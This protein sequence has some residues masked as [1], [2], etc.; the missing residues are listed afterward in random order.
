MLLT[1]GPV[2][3]PLAVVAAGAAP[4]MHHRSDEFRQLLGV[5]ATRL[6][7]L[8]GSTGTV[9]IQAGS[10]TLAMQAAIDN[11]CAPGDYAVVCRTGEFAA[12]FVEMV[13]AAGGVA[14]PVDAPP[15][16]ALPPESLAE[17][18]RKVSVRL[19]CLQHVDTSSGIRNDVAALAAVARAVGAYVV[20]DGVASV[21]AEHVCADAHG[22]DV[23]VTA[24]QK[25]LMCPPGV[26]IQVIS[27]RA[28]A[29][30]RPVAPVYTNWT[31]RPAE[32]GVICNF[33]AP[34]NGVRALNAAT[35]E[36]AGYRPA[37]LAAAHLREADAVRAG[38]G[39]LGMSIVADSSARAAFVT[40][41]RPPAPV[42][43]RDLHRELSR[44]GRLV[45]RGEGTVRIGHYL[46]NRLLDPA[47]VVAEIG[48]AL[49]D[50]GRSSPVVAD[51][52][53]AAESATRNRPPRF[54]SVDYRGLAVDSAVQ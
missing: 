19:V 53:A 27:D 29:A 44:R 43:A 36:L 12:R 37:A 5:T 13:A 38:L 28:L 42:S 40:A 20:V 15:G 14:I 31:R 51:A 1:P 6:R 24:S 3:V 54:G 11:L 26:A 45:A 32:A 35:A 21:G 30:A 7:K 48:A 18:C 22:L 25:G 2:E 50:L 8:T 41:A 23:V 33:T 17:A 47:E 10:G 34:V 4:A 9:A 52:V 46:L 16:Q 39:V 49:I